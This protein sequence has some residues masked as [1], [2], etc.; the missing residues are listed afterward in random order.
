MDVIAKARAKVEGDEITHEQLKH[1]G[2]QIADQFH[3][4]LKT[5]KNP[6]LKVQINGLINDAIQGD[7]T[8]LPTRNAR[9]ISKRLSATIWKITR[10]LMKKLSWTPLKIPPNARGFCRT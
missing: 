5:A 8:A 10:Q 7:K 9:L 2:K 3:K 6:H 4:N 1:F